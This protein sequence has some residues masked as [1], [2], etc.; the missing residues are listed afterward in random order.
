MSMGSLGS[1]G[2]S[3]RISI[4]GNYNAVAVIG[5]DLLE[6]WDASR[7]ETIT[8]TTDA[9]YTN[10]VSSWS[11]LVL[12]SN[13]VQS[14]PNLKPTYSPTGLA[15]SPCINHDGTQQYLTC[16]DAALL[17]ALP[18][19]ATPGEIWVLLSQDALAAD[20]TERYAC[21]WSGTSVVT[22]RAISRTVTSGTNRARGR[23]GIGASATSV[24]DAAV[25]FSGIHV[26]RHIVGA[27]TSSLS[28]D[29]GVPTTAAAVPATTNQRFRVGAISAAAASNY[30]Q[31]KIAA[32][33]VTKPLSD[34]KAAALH[35]YLG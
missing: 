1:L 30:W 16:T 13:L 9:T 35:S 17:A 33:L 3:K 28:V 7:G 22:G 2:A 32:I 11:G 23:T 5:S 21:G 4:G 18:S 29:G 19:G 10:A 6:M 20:T 14:T 27:T 8:A 26:I 24:N 25:D 31:G 12:G 34:D 15:G